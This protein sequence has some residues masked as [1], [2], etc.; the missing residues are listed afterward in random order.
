[1]IC[2][3]SGRTREYLGSLTAGV[4]ELVVVP[5]IR[6]PWSVIALNRSLQRGPK[7]CVVVT[8]QFSATA[9]SLYLWARRARVPFVVRVRGGMANEGADTRHSH[10]CGVK[11]RQAER[12]FLLRHANLVLTV[13]SYLKSQILCELPR[14]PAERLQVS[15]EPVRMPFTGDPAAFRRLWRISPRTQILLSVSAFKFRR[16]Y[17]ALEY[18]HDTVVSALIR[19][20][21]WCYVIAGDGPD[22]SR[23]RE[24]LLAQTP[25]EIRHRV[26]LVGFV[27]RIQDALA[28]ADAVLHLSFRE[29]AG[30]VV[31][32]A[33]ASGRPV[34]VNRSGGGMLEFMPDSRYS[35][36]SREDL[37]IALEELMTNERLRAEMG[38]RNL[39]H[40]QANYGE[41][42]IRM[43]LLADL[44][45]IHHKSQ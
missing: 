13:S 24:K 30:Q 3:C 28:S 38:E 36:E 6:M 21:N 27:S 22:Y 17:E 44:Q 20:P 10:W 9:V 18:Y 43:D 45:G 15:L 4:Y 7:P 1:M 32:E 29:S 31:K 19:H 11:W 5:N 12:D 16:K 25:R 23:A 37:L 26:L 42:R 8:D 39:A 14:I 34:L 33:Q 2:Y 40:A 35:V 41:G